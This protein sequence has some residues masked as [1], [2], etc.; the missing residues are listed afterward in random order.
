MMARHNMAPPIKRLI[1]CWYDISFTNM[2]RKGD[3][4]NKPMNWVTNQ[5]ASVLSG[6]KLFAIATGL[7]GVNPIDI[8]ISV[9]TKL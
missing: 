1:Y 8:I 6:N 5:Y 9:I 7:K 3:R 4:I 2:V